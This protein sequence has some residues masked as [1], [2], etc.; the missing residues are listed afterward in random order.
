[1]A[2]TQMLTLG[3]VHTGLLQHSTP[4]SPAG[5]E[6]I[7][8]LA[9]GERVRRFERPIS[10]AVSPDLLTGVDCPLATS[11]GA[12]VRGIGTVR[13]RA[14]ITGGHVLQG[15]AMVQVT[16]G[17]SAGRLPW[18]HYLARPGQVETTGRADWTDL[19]RGF[20]AARSA[21]AA[22]LDLGAVSG[23][24]MDT[25]QA[26][27][28]L[29]RR[30]PFRVARTRLRWVAFSVDRPGAHP[31]DD[32]PRPV[33]QVAFRIEGRQLRTLRLRC[34]AEEAPGVAELCEDL[35]LH[36]WLLSTLLEVMERSRIGSGPRRQAVDRLAPAIDHLLHLWMPAAR[37]DGDLATVWESLE[38]RP[39]LSRQWH[40]SVNRIRDQLALSTIALL[41]RKPSGSTTAA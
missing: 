29:D 30:P 23:R 14:A 32:P 2:V 7:L 31:P 38:R 33:R 3:E 8:G 25:V 10:Y 18:P 34:A 17:Q 26:M 11:S 40:A 5:A 21:T 4:L 15:S 28:G 16:S 13:H 41:G 19:A 9:Q 6:H 27:P 36:D 20:V 22:T 39:G 24:L 12:R 35:A 1:M 37:L